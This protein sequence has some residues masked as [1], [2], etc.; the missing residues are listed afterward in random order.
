MP[1]D[2]VDGRTRGRDHIGDSAEDSGTGKRLSLNGADA[3]T[4][5]NSDIQSIIQ[6]VQKGNKPHAGT[7]QEEENIIR[8]ILVDTAK[9]KKTIDAIVR[10]FAGEGYKISTQTAKDIQALYKAGFDMTKFSLKGSDDYN[11]RKLQAENEMLRERVDYWKGQTKRTERVTTD[12]KAVAKAARDLVRQYG[13]DIDAADIQGDL[14]SLYDYMASGKDGENDLTYTAARERAEGIADKLISHAVEKE[15]ELYQQYSDLRQFLKET[16]LTV[17]EADSKGLA[18][19][20]DFR[21]RNLGHFKLSKGQKTNVDTVYKE[22]SERW[23]EFFDEERDS[24]ISDQIYQIESVMD[25]VYQITEYNPFDRYTSQAVSG[26]AN[27]IL[28]RFFDLPQ[29]RATFADRQA[30]KLDRE[31]AAGRR[32]LQEE[33]ERKDAKLEELR[34]K[35]R[36]RVDKVIQKERERR[37]KDLGRLKD[38]YQARDAAGRERRKARE[39]RAK[40]LRHTK[41]LSTKLLRPN[42]KQHIRRSRR[43]YWNKLD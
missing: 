32:R 22:M 10:S 23:P 40:I 33:R 35:N 13:A 36:E 21:R 34:Q 17:S 28:E 15:D 27:E 6:K 24:S 16:K 39:L 9:G 31:K 37:E 8:T 26:A 1:T 41:N 30:A 2:G 43:G 42:D 3:T 11:L 5:L 7:T 29:T 25:K 20:A 14:Q 4:A 18:D 12:K 38:Q 19:Y